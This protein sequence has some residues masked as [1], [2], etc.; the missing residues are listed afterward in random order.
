MS[1]LVASNLTVNRGGREILR[2]LDVAFESG[3]VTA[4]LGPNGS[5]KSTLLATLAGLLRANGGGVR[6][7]E[8][9]IAT[10]PALV[11]AQRLGFLHQNPEIVW[12]VDVETVVGLG[13]IPHRHVST[14][15]H[16]AEAVSEALRITGTAEW[17]TRDVTTLSG[18]ERARVLLA[19]VLAGEPEWILADEPFAGLDPAHQFETAEMFRALAAQ[20]RGVVVT[21]HD[22]TLAA[23]VADRVIVLTDGRVIADGPPR[24]AL[25]TDILMNA[26]GIEARWIDDAAPMIAI[27]GRRQR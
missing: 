25:S 15:A 3:F 12:A 19:R 27:T 18:G 1:V 8:Q 26:Y 22:L 17:A 10:L 5:G 21:L 23:R 14:K 2:S 11:R 13:R 4:V 6:L 16:D 7:D 9:N 20:G 24:T